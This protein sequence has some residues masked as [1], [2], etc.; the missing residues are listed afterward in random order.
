MGSEQEV[1]ILKCDVTEDEMQPSL[2]T[3]KPADTHAD[4]KGLV[5]ELSVSDLKCIRDSMVE[6]NT[7]LE[8][9]PA[10][11]VLRRVQSERCF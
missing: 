6:V 8:V 7:F 2:V 1:E 11:A 3:P 10:K 5:F 9:R 4:S